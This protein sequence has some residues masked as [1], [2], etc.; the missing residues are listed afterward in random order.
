MNFSEGGGGPAW[1]DKN[2]PFFGERKARTKIYIFAIIWRFRLTRLKEDYVSAHSASEIVWAFCIDTAYDILFFKFQGEEGLRLPQRLFYNIEKLSSYQ[3]DL[4]V[5]YM[6][7]HE[8]TSLVISLHVHV[9][10]YLAWY[11]NHQR[12]LAHFITNKA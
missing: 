1:I 12:G 2:D 5:P 3:T 6:H 10:A 4:S 9:L 8:K 7:V 11:S